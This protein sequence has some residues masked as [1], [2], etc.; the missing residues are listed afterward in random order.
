MGVDKSYK[1]FFDN[2][3]T[4]YHADGSK[5]VTYKNLQIMVIQ[6]ARKFGCGYI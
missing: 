6:H 1:N 2:G 4:T 5:S 3:I